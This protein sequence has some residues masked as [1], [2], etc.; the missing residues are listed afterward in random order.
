MTPH[1]QIPF[2]MHMIGK[3][4]HSVHLPLVTKLLLTQI[5]LLA[6]IDTN[7]KRLNL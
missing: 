4:I 2:F 6:F 5:V 7:Y 3:S 1:K